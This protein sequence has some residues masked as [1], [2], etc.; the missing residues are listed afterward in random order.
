M[1]PRLIHTPEE[2]ERY[3]AEALGTSREYRMFP[4]DLGWVI[5]PILSEQE[6]S[7]GRHIGLSKM[8]LDARTG[9]I[10]ELPSLPVETVAQMYTAAIREGTRMP[11][12]QIYPPRTRLHVNLIR[13]NPTTVEYLIRPESTT[14]P[15]PSADYLLVI[16]KDTRMYQPPGTVNM[17]AAAWIDHRRRT[18]GTWPEQGTT[19]Y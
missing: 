11:G 16:D 8:V 18:D 13:D 15:R 14:D 4:F 2:A 9:V 7:Q 17:M 3:L 6:I 12:G 19:Q 10:T 5:Y 1:S